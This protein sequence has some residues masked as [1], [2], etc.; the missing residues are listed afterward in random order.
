MKYETTLQPKADKAALCLKAADYLAF[1][2]CCIY[3]S[4]CIWIY[5]VVGANNKAA[6]LPYVMLPFGLAI[7]TVLTLVRLLKQPIK[8]QLGHNILLAAVVVG[9]LA[10]AFCWGTIG[11]EAIINCLCTLMAVCI[12]VY[13]LPKYLL[14]HFFWLLTAILFIQIS[15][16]YYQ[17]LAG[18]L[19]SHKPP[20][21]RGHWN[22]AAEFASYML[23]AYPLLLYTTIQILPHASVVGKAYQRNKILLP[24]IGT[25]LMGQLLCHIGSARHWYLFVFENVF[26]GYIIARSWLNPF[27]K[28]FHLLNRLVMGWGLALGALIYIVAFSMPHNLMLL[29]LLLGILLCINK[30]L[31]GLNF[32]FYMRLYLVIC[33]LLA[34]DN[35]V[36]NMP[37]ILFIAVVFAAFLCAIVAIGPKQPEVEVPCYML[38]LAVLALFA[39]TLLATGK[40]ATII[41]LSGKDFKII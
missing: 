36:F 2:F 12:L 7:L 8:L 39:A 29:Y 41:R 20:V 30:M 9:C 35:Y 31:V 1:A 15:Q 40:L 27:S 22:T 14:G 24:L 33:C 18:R 28:K 3:Y 16:G 26:S 17:L 37:A 38:M 6:F 32:I 23:A 34:M 4:Y 21:I 25:L 10:W 13:Y 19:S 5:P 11:N